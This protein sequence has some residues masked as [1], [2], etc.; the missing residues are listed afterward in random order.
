MLHRLALADTR[1]LFLDDTDGLGASR[2]CE[3]QLAPSNLIPK[4]CPRSR[5]ACSLGKF[6]VS[7]A[8]EE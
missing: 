4:Y 1:V 3:H 6:V 8:R 2:F 7:R 5:G